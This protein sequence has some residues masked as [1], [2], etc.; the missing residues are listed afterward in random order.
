MIR[1][2]IMRERY[3]GLALSRLPWPHGIDGDD[4]GDTQV[5][6]LTSIWS[7]SVA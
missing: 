3:A 2:F 7:T 1:D 4:H 5:V 6:A